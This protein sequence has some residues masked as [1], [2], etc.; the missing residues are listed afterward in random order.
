M[1]FPPMVYSFRFLLK[2]HRKF[3]FFEHFLGAIRGHSSSELEEEEDEEDEEDDNDESELYV[4]ITREDA[5]FLGV[6]LLFLPYK[7]FDFAFLIR[8]F[9]LIIEELAFG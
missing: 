6:G 9:D 4:L 2:D 5:Y 7:V 3:F 8:S 1:S